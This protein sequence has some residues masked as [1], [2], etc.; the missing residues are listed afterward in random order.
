MPTVNATVT[1]STRNTNKND[2]TNAWRSRVAAQNLMEGDEFIM[3]GEPNIFVTKINRN[4]D[5]GTVAV[6]FSNGM[7]R[8]YSW[9]RKASIVE[10][11]NRHRYRRNSLRRNGYPN[12]L[13]VA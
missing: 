10:T 4:E 9:D 13:K 1:A 7:K 5:N 3:R 11:P 6:T 12:Y 8:K 2:T